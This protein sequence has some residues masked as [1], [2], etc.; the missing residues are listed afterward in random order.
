[1][2]SFS[3]LFEKIYSL[4]N[5]QLALDK[6]SK[7]KKGNV[8]VQG[9]IKN[10][11][12]QL[13]KL[14]NELKDE[15]YS[16][17]PY[18]Q[19]KILDPKPRLISCADFRDRIVHHAVCNIIS[20]LLERSFIMDSYACLKGRGSHRAVLRT[21]YFCKKYNYY[22]KSDISNFFDSIDR[23][24]LKGLLLKRFR[25]PKLKQLLS[26]LIDCSTGIDKGLPIGNL[27]S[28]WFANLYMNQLDRFIK[29]TLHIKG[30]VRYMDDFVLWGNT[31]DE[32]FHAWIEVKDFLE[33]NLKLQLKESATLVS[34]TS[35]GLNFL[36]IQ[37][38][39]N[40]LRFGKARMKRTRKLIKRRETEFKTGVINE[41]ELIDSVRSSTAS[42]AYLGIQC[43]FNECSL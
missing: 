3:G 6:S 32:M 1:M 33:S 15:V 39:P 30:Y 37:V 16:P 23:T 21:Q 40:Q 43:C 20:P 10:K 4:D 9:F 24:I 22:F 41:K 25:E 17:Q 13:I 27:T 7:G 36:G 34:P 18:T 11:A 26:T 2:K 5:L 12:L 42:A 8:G 31:K 38:Y 19:F 28:Q 29:E 14:S 35:S